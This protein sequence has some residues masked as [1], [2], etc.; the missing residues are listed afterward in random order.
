MT[1]FVEVKTRAGTGFGGPVAAVGATKQRRIR[2]LASEWLAQHRGPV[3]ALRFDV[4]AIS[5]VDI[6]VFESAF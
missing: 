6:E 2:R 3:G 4:V 5:G 1:V